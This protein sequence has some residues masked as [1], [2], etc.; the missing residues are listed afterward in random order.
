LLRGIRFEK[1]HTGFMDNFVDRP[2]FFAPGVKNADLS[3]SALIAALKS[4]PAKSRFSH[5]A[6]TLN[7]KLPAARLVFLKKPKTPDKLYKT[8]IRRNE[9]EPG[10]LPAARERFAR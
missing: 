1:N 3:R 10:T 4:L 8:G 2:G 7:V 6:G 5:A 9:P